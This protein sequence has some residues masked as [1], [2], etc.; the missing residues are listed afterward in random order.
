MSAT[1]PF[2][3]SN[4]QYK[5]LDLWYD[6]FENTF[7]Q[8][9]D[10][11]FIGIP[12]ESSLYAVYVDNKQHPY[13]EY[14]LRNVMYFLGPKWGLQIFV[15][16]ENKAFVKRIVKDW[17]YVHVTEVPEE[18]Y[19]GNPVDAVKRSTGFWDRVKG[20]KQLFFDIDTLLC[21]RNVDNFLGYDYIGAPWLGAR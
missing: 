14:V 7:N 15:W 5:S 20:D 19:E 18:T 2:K 9:K 13:L 17:N 6:F 11:Q 16:P 12:E 21:N 1:I 4:E 3:Y 8:L 10:I